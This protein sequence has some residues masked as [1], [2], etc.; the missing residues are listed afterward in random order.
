MEDETGIHFCRPLNFTSFYKESKS[1]L[2]FIYQGVFKKEKVFNKLLLEI[3]ETEIKH[4]F[5]E[6]SDFLIQN[7]SMTALSSSQEL[8][9]SNK[10]YLID[11]DNQNESMR[12]L[13]ES[14]N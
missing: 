11:E 1:K 10:E 2:D 13:I 7:V 9:G 6:K 8:S 12:L 3:C 14:S 5:L 4:E